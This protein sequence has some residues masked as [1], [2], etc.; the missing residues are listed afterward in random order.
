MSTNDVTGD[1]IYSKPS[2]SYESNYGNIFSK[3]KCAW[4]GESVE[5]S[6]AISYKGKHY[7]SECLW[8]VKE[9]E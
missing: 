7:H 5:S 1:L 3:K 9:R 4:C 8:D 6:E 2:R